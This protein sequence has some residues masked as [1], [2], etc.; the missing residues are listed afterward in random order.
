MNLYLFW[1]DC[2]HGKNRNVMSKGKK[3][4][5]KE[6]KNIASVG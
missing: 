6:N 3:T 4:K 2:D 1:L 5:Q